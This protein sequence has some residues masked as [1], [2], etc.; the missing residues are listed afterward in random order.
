MSLYLKSNPNHSIRYI[1]HP[2]FRLSTIYFFSSL[3]E[4][5]LVINSHWHKGNSRKQQAMNTGLFCRFNTRKA[6]KVAINAPIIL[7]MCML[8]NHCLV[9][10]SSFREALISTQTIESRKLPNTGK[11]PTAKVTPIDINKALHDQLIP[12][13][14][15]V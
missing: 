3:D 7:L 4:L 9:M 5:P 15:I 12:L 14:H 11:T 6:V 8:R 2:Y 1:Y 13:I 10:V